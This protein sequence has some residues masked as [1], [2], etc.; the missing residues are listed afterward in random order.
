MGG[1][2]LPLV[3]CGAGLAGALAA[4]LGFMAL[5]RIKTSAG[6]LRGRALAWTGI[7]TGI[8]TTLLSMAWLST[9]NSLQTAWDQQLAQGVKL[10]FAAQDD[11]AA[12][13]AL[14]SWSASQNASLSAADLEAFAV[15]VRERLGAFESM[16]LVTKEMAPSLTGDHM[17]THVVNFDFDGGRRSGAL[18]ARLRVGTDAWTPTLQLASITINDADAP[19]GIIELP[20]R[21]KRPTAGEDATT[22][23]VT[24]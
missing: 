11:E 13:K 23:E 21:K 15:T 6:F 1:V 9:I 7:S 24:P 3:C 10:T 12:R 14:Q 19:G 16:G 5:D 20:V 2:A 18:T 4:L 22:K 17:L 8:A